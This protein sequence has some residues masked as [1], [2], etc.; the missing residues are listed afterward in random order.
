MKR[1]SAIALFIAATFITAG[2]AFA[3][4]NQVMANVPFSFTVGNSTLPSGTYTIRSRVASPRV[5]SLNSWDKGV[6]VMTIGQPDQNNPKRADKLVFH[7]YGNQY[8]LSE[9]LC[10][11]ESMNIHFATTKAEKRARTQTNSAGLFVSDPVL[12]ALNR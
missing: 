8:F 3:Q 10:S 12:I 1:I 9:I 11:D 4:D 5:L 2:S 7:K 6:H